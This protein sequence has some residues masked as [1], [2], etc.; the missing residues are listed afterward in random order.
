MSTVLPYTY[1][2]PTATIGAPT[3]NPTSGPD[4][5]TSF[6]WFQATAVASRRS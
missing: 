5:G 4:Q 2:R 3:A 1:E 6:V